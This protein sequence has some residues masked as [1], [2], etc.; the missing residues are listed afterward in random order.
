MGEDC[1][2][3][4]ECVEDGV[5][6]MLRG[7]DSRHMAGIR[8]ADPSTPFDPKNG[9]NSAQDD[10]VFMVRA[11]KTEHLRLARLRAQASQQVIGDANGVGYG[12][13]VAIA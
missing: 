4:G 8:T 7:V 9:P 6:V 11:S 2:G 3:D 13:V 5:A 10:R 12:G 1:R